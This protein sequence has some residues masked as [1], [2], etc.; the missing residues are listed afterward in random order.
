MKPR[1]ANIEGRSAGSGPR[2]ASGGE[3]G[4]CQVVRLGHVNVGKSL[5]DSRPILP[6]CVDYRLVVE[7]HRAGQEERLG[8]LAA[9]MELCGALD[10]FASEAT[11]F[12]EVALDEPVLVVVDRTLVPRPVAAMTD[13]GKISRVVH[14]KVGMQAVRLDVLADPI[15]LQVLGQ[16][17]IDLDVSERLRLTTPVAPMRPGRIED[18]P[19]HEISVVAVVPDVAHSYLR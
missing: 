18:E 10:D 1:S 2:P 14:M 13:R 19:E 3:P 5:N 17:V 6:Q 12:V 15:G 11:S 8:N 16:N 4:V 9:R 7:G